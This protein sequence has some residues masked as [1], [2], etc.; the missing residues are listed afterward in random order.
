[1][2]IK[3]S[4]SQKKGRDW[5]IPCSHARFPTSVALY[6]APCCPVSIGPPPPGVRLLQALPCLLSWPLCASFLS[7]ARLFS[8]LFFCWPQLVG[9]Y[10]QF[11]VSVRQLV[12]SVCMR[13][14]SFYPFLMQRQGGLSFF[15][16]KI[17]CSASLSLVVSMML[18]KLSK[19]KSPRCYPSMFHLS[20]PSCELEFLLL[21]VGGSFFFD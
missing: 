4:S 10:L 5:L 2:I 8:L 21:H 13:L 9:L 19:L 11:A 3:L 1:L 20:W 6:G 12:L 17:I 15:F 18:E 7:F 16:K 14:C